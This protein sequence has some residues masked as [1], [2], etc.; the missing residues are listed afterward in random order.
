MPARSG[1]SMLQIWVELLLGCALPTLFFLPFPFMKR[2]LAWAAR[3]FMLMMSDHWALLRL[4]ATLYGIA[5]A[6]LAAIAIHECGHLLAGLATGFRC[7]S[8]RFGRFRIEKGFKISRYQNLE[9]ASL[10]WAKM[11][12]VYSEHLRWRS[13]AMIVAGPLANLLSACLVIKLLPD[14]SFISGSFIAV[15]IYFGIG[16]LLPIS[17]PGHV[18]DGQRLWMLWF[19]RKRSERYFAMLSLTDQIHHGVPLDALDP[20]VLER[21]VSLHDRSIETV[22]A[23]LFGYLAATSRKDYFKAS[24]CLENALDASGD[25]PPQLREMLMVYAAVFQA[26]RRGRLDLAEQW[27]AAAPEKTVL[28]EARALLEKQIVSSKQS[29]PL[30]SAP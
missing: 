20:V 23:Q 17:I 8:F 21:A 4:F 18:N 19:D 30:I 5:L 3:N 27:L 10:G 9:D 26:A 2:F 14:P 25:A 1:M 12:P 29:A 24:E 15:S 11:V 16:N 13:F 7:E 6:C 28:L 22:K